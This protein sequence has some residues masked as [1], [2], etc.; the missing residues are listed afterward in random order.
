MSLDPRDP[1]FYLDPYPAF[2]AMREAAPLAYWE[3]F[4]H[5]CASSHALVQALLRD[6]R[7]GRQILHVATR[8]EL[9][10]PTRPDGLAAFDALERHSLLELEPPAHTRLRGLVNRAF[11]SR[12]VERLGP[13]IAARAHRLIDGFAERGRCDLVADYAAPIPVAVIAELIGAPEEAIP[14]LLDWSHRLVEMYRLD[15]PADVRAS[16]DSAARDFADFLRALVAERRRAPRDDLLSRLVEARTAQGALGDDE[17]VSTAALLL[18]AGHEATVHAIGNAFDALLEHGVDPRGRDIERLAEETLRFDP[19]LH[20]FTRYALEDAEVAGVRIGRGE[21]VGLLL[22]AANR[23]PAA[24]D[25]PDRFDPVR[26]PGPHVAFGAGI[27]FCL[28][29]PLARLELR[30]VLAPPFARLRNLRRDGPSTIKDAWHFRGRA[31][32]PVTWDA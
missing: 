11:V 7:F 10:W 8:E 3:E 24:F 19:P 23:D 20:L 29:A 9:G 21:R 15:P 18:N 25:V 27:H 31:A 14:A 1:A 32:L 16:A 4:G 22:G 13:A 28:G 12:E 30:E 5:W 17:I 6:R 26:A 2:A